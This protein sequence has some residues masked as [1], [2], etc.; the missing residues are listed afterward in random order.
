M[1]ARFLRERCIHPLLWCP[2]PTPISIFSKVVELLLG[3]RCLE[4]NHIQLPM[5]RETNGKVRYASFAVIK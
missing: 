3:D 1:H 4:L 5:Q 2:L